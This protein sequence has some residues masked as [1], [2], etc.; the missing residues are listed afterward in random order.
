[1]SNSIKAT[2]ETKSLTDQG[3]E[4]AFGRKAEYEINPI[5]LQRWSPRAF[6][7]EEIPGPVLWGALEAA[8]GAPSGSSTQPWRFIYSKRGSASWEKFLDLLN[9]NNRRWAEKASALI[10]FI[11]KKTASRN[12]EVVPSKSHSFDAGAA[13]QNWTAPLSLDSFHSKER[14]GLTAIS[15]SGFEAA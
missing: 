4:G 8:R 6:T 12:G 15:V 14:I 10:L 7:G 9:P 13:W 1:M 2:L 3:G 5:F 11:S